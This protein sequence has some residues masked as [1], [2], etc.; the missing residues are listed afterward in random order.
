MSPL[1]RDAT[2]IAFLESLPSWLGFPPSED[3][4]THREAPDRGPGH[5]TERERFAR[6]NEKQP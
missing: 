4:Q 5:Q 3:G 1:E 6:V 2:N